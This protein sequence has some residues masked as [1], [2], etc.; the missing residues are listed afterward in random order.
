MA[1]Q[2][3]PRERITAVI[4]RI[5]PVQPLDVRR[6]L[7]EGDTVL[8]GAILSEMVAH[9]MLAISRT[10]R[11]GSPFYY[12]PSKPETLERVSEFLGEK[13]RRTYALLKEQQVLREDAQ[14]PLTRVSL[15]NIPDFSRRFV[16]D[17]DAWWRYYLLPEEDAVRLV[18]ERMG[19]MAPQQVQQ[20]IVQQDAHREQVAQAKEQ[21]VAA[22]PESPPPPQAPEREPEPPKKK[23]RP[24]R[25][26]A[27][28]EER[29]IQ[30]PLTIVSDVLLSKIELFAKQHGGLLTGSQIIK[31]DAELTCTLTVPGAFGN[32]SY[33]VHALAKKPA[34]KAVMQMMLAARG[35]GM[36]LL[37]LAPELPKKIESLGHNVNARRI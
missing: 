8:I 22:A 5:G 7:K 19:I 11:G 3:I 37:V 18:K 16:V 36:P 31:K 10:K 28:S 17:G 35:S 26:K 6:E 12:L 33:F 32:I 24:A 14:E 1:F 9:G 21:A 30:A 27:A 13:D 25:K 15:Q 29:E 4:E 34:E 23:A 20:T 2:A